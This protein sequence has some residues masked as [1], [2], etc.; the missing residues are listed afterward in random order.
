[1]PKAPHKLKPL[2]LI[3]ADGLSPRGQA[4]GDGR[5]IFSSRTKFRK[6]NEHRK[7]ICDTGT[8]DGMIQASTVKSREL[9]A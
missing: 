9:T 6:Q 2:T 4:N 8:R 3:L 7:L 1:M 5:K